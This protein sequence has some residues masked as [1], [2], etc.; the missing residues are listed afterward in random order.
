MS[1][2]LVG[3]VNLFKRL[4]RSVLV[5]ASVSD[6]ACFVH[7][8]LVLIDMWNMLSM[9]SDN[10]SAFLTVRVAM[11]FLIFPLGPLDLPADYRNPQT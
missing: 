7:S 9:A 6:T 4:Y 2:P 3:P 10:S 1:K 8:V 5:F 11:T